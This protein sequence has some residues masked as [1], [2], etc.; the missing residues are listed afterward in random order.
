MLDDVINT[1]TECNAY[2]ACHRADQVDDKCFPLNGDAAKK[3]DDKHD[4]K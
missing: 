3:D 4:D 1:Q 2:I